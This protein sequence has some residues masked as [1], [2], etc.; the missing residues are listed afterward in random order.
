M[1]DPG[2]TC[3]GPDG[4]RLL[5]CGLQEGALVTLAVWAAG[6]RVGAH[7][8]QS[9]RGRR[10]HRHEHAQPARG[11]R[12]HRYSARR[13][14]RPQAQ[15]TAITSDATIMPSVR[16]V[17]SS[18][19]L[20]ALDANTAWLASIP[21][22]SVADSAAKLAAASPDRAEPTAAAWFPASSCARRAV[23]ARYQAWASVAAWAGSAASSVPGPGP[24]SFCWAR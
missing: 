1:N 22:L 16:P 6:A 9:Q 20:R 2:V 8:T 5:A 15:P 14:L 4:R 7:G 24:R 11:P 17:K 21:W 19:P 13:R 10:Q 23:W 3:G 18:R 12:V